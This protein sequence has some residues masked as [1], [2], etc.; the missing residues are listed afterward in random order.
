MNKQITEY[1]ERLNAS[2]EPNKLD[3]LTKETEEL[4]R[5]FLINKFEGI[6]ARVKKQQEEILEAEKKRRMDE[7]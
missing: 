2:N 5:Q 4:Y 1:F 3:S 6:K 7:Y